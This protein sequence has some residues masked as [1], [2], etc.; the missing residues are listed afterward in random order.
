[1]RMMPYLISPSAATMRA[2]PGMLRPTTLQRRA[3]HNVEYSFIP[4][5][6]FRDC[7][8][9]DPKASATTWLAE[10]IQH[11]C[12]MA[13]PH[14]SR[15]EVYMS[16]QGFP[17]TAHGQWMGQQQ[18]F[19]LTKDSLDPYSNAISAKMIVHDLD[20]GEMQISEHFERACWTFDNW[21]ISKHVL[22]T[23]PDLGGHIKVY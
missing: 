8:I 18:H 22:D 5:P 13:W 19:G 6:K 10:L 7:F 12:Y 9:D 23:W 20:S 2:M 16:S 15:E 14:F 17:D 3:P 1:M 11:Q 21:S 4:I